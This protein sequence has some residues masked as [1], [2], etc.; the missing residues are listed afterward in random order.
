V[1][2]KEAKR[3][4]AA[5]YMLVRR[6]DPL[7]R[8]P[9]CQDIGRTI[10]FMIGCHLIDQHGCLAVLNRAKPHI[11]SAPAGMDLY[12]YCPSACFTG[13]AKPEELQGGRRASGV[14]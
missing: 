13:D 4:L 12:L 11:M 14:V 8:L 7:N 9:Q 5:T 1:M 6:E 3:L 2:E 10:R